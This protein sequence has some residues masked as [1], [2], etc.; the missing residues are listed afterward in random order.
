MI[1][2]LTGWNRSSVVQITGSLPAQAARLGRHGRHDGFAGALVTGLAVPCG[3][4]HPVPQ[5]GP[6]KR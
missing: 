4:W 6:R 2:S 3:R 1:D 5:G